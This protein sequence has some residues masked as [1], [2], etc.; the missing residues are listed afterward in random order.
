[1]LDI[2]I[3]YLF[4]YPVINYR[5]RSGRL[6]I[7]III[8]K[9]LSLYFVHHAFSLSQQYDMSGRDTVICVAYMRHRQL[10][11]KEHGF[12]HISWWGKI[13]QL[14]LPPWMKQERELDS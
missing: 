3:L 4:N 8:S 7:E 12:L 9:L 13:T 5:A 14:L 10:K 6:L 1:M 2:F 11:G